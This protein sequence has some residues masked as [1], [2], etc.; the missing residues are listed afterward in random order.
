MNVRANPP[1]TDPA[2]PITFDGVSIVTTEEITD[3]E[4]AATVTCQF[5]VDEGYKYRVTWNMYVHSP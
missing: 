5:N 2:D 3:T 4:H 1:F